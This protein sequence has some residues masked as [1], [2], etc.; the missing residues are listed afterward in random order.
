[1]TDNAKEELSNFDDV[2]F[3]RL[4]GQNAYKA[5]EVAGLTPKEAQALIFNYSN[6]QMSANR[7]S[8]IESGA[9]TIDAKILYKMALTYGC[10][11]DYLMGLN[12]DIDSNIAAIHNGIVHQSVRGTMLEVGDRITASMTQLMR[13]LPPFQGELVVASAKKLVDEVKKQKHDIAFRGSYMEL[14]DKALQLE[15]NVR[16][17]DVYMARQMR[18]LELNMIEQIDAIEQGALQTMTSQNKHT[19]SIE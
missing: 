16:R 15:E 19:D 12:S 4:I 1:M 8:E 18:L 11:V 17:F 2:K 13:Y 10:S 6:K 9:K 7:I 5:R 3:R 14:I